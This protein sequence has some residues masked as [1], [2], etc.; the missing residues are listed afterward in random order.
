[1]AKQ[2]IDTTTPQPDGRFGDPLLLMTEKINQNTTELFARTGGDKSATLAQT[3][4][5][6]GIDYFGASAPVATFPCMTWADTANQLMK[7]RNSDDTAWTILGALFFDNRVRKARFN[8]NGTFVVP[9]GVTTVWV[10]G[11]AGGGG[12]GGGAGLVSGN[13]T[14]CGGGGGAGQSTIGQAI[15][16]T[17]GESLPVVIGGAGAGGNGGSG[18]N[19]AGAKGGD[20]GPTKL[21]NV[22]TLHGG[23]G[24]GG[25]TSYDSGGP[26]G[27]GYPHGGWGMLV[28]LV[29]GS[30]YVFALSGAGGSG[31]FGGGGNSSIVRGG[32][33]N[34]YGAWGYGGGGGGGASTSGAGSPGGKG[35][36]GSPGMLIIEW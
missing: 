15:T 30:T 36:A 29:P 35:G 11:C 2:L 7:R 28:T 18:D 27:A 20:G 3:R 13:T 16:V 19:Q 1:M 10:S 14:I 21:G 4:Q 12:G 32:G 24:G 34:G 9:A 8:A 23:A 6:M 5:N 31:P 17:P 22:L 25:G 33:T 26:P